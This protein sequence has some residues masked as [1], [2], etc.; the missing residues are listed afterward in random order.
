MKLLFSSLVF[1]VSLRAQDSAAVLKNLMCRWHFKD[2]IRKCRGGMEEQEMLTRENYSILSRPSACLLPAFKLAE[3][4]AL[5]AMNHPNLAGGVGLLSPG[6]AAAGWQG[7]NESPIGVKA[8]GWVCWLCLEQQGDSWCHRELWHREWD[9][10]AKSM[11]THESPEDVTEEAVTG[12]ELSS[13]RALQQGCRGE[14]GPRR[15]NGKPLR[16]GMNDMLLA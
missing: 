9:V 11:V 8:A 13:Q 1:P 10:S 6:S 16:R 4:P 3:L 7:C 12:E 15:D 2:A 14:R 5:C